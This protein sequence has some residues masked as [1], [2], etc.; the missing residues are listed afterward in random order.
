VG[1]PARDR[2]P[3]AGSAQRRSTT[4]RIACTSAMV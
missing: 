1:R 3:V 2:H 4:V